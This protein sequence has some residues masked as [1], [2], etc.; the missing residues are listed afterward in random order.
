[1]RNPRALAVDP[2]CLVHHHPLGAQ[3]APRER[4][5][6]SRTLA[7]AQ[8]RFALPALCFVVRAREG[9]VRPAAPVWQ[10]DAR[11]ASLMDKFAQGAKGVLAYSSL[12][13]FFG[14]PALPCPH[15]A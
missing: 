7:T 2:H 3:R 13:T 4:V 8:A 5:R 11:D 12:S 14:A 1:M 15:F 6:H 10:G 9:C